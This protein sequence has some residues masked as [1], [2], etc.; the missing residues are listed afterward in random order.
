M[1]AQQ[2]IEALR[3]GVPE[4][5]G[6]GKPEQETFA[7]GWNRALEQAWGVLSQQPEFQIEMHLQA[8]DGYGE[9][10]HTVIRADDGQVVLRQATEG[11]F[12]RWY[13]AHSFMREAEGIEQV[14]PQFRGAYL[15]RPR[16]VH[17]MVDN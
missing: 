14:N 7:Q 9:D 12:D 5:I 2:V 6:F 15:E 1:D 3:A 17:F 4:V 16:G 11:E 8:V 10:R 13:A